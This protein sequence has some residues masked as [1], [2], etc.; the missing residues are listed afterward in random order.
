MQGSIERPSHVGSAPAS[1]SQRIALHLVNRE[2]GH[3][4]RRIY[5]DTKTDKPVEK[6]DQVKGD[7]TSEGK[8]VVLEPDEIAAAVTESDKT[9]KKHV[10][11][12]L[13]YSAARIN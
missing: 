6:D 10:I 4:L 8:Y 7:E 2:T 3:R 1:S 13:I 5:A 12:L 9:L 11:T